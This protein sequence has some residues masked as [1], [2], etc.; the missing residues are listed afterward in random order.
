MPPEIYDVAEN[1]LQRKLEVRHSVTEW[2][3]TIH[4]QTPTGGN[5]IQ[6]DVGA[7]S[8]APPLTAH[9]GAETVAYGVA[10]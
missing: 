9:T 1:F 8:V 4:P 7:K 6:R 2:R 5:V 10:V 3:F